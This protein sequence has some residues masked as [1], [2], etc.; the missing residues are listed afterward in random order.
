[1]NNE[2]HQ[3]IVDRI[4]ALDEETARLCRQMKKVEKL[5][6]IEMDKLFDWKGDARK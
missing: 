3:K 1:M 2:E 5:A 6:E 4:T